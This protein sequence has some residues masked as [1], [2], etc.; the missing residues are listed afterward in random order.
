MGMRI[1]V[2]GEKLFCPFCGAADDDGTSQCAC[3][4]SSW[5]RN[6]LGNHL[7]YWKHDEAHKQTCAI[8]QAPRKG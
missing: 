4:A 2:T 6:C 3:G 8:C 7:H 1:S 5:Q